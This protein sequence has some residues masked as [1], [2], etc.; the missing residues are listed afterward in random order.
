MKLNVRTF[1]ISTLSGGLIALGSTMALAQQVNNI[2]NT[3]PGESG[4]GTGCSNFVGGCH[5]S[6]VSSAHGAY[7][8]TNDLGTG[9][10][11]MST[12]NNAPAASPPY[13]GCMPA[14]EATPGH[15]MTGGT[16]K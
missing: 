6:E 11:P 10:T 3:S 9:G 8:P 5:A 2:D 7:Q 12:S 13:V 4:H 1:A 15:C 14:S 16:N